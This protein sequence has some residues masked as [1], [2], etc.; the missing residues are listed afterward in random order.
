MRVSPPAAARIKEI[1]R[2]QNRLALLTLSQIKAAGLEMEWCEHID[3]KAS[4]IF[5]PVPHILGRA[6]KPDRAS[7]L[8]LPF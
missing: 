5:P 4:A 6:R 8:T 1:D 2:S 7:S 3:F